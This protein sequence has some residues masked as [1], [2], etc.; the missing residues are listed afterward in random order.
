SK[1]HDEG[2]LAMVLEAAE[3]LIGSIDDDR[4]KT[5]Y[6]L[7]HVTELY[8]LADYNTALRICETLHTQLNSKEH[9]E[10]W[11]QIRSLH[12]K[13]LYAMDDF[14]RADSLFDDFEH[15]Q[16][17]LYAAQYVG[18]GMEISENY[19]LEKFER[20]IK[21]QELLLSNTYYQRYG[22]ITGIVV[23]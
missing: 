1:I 15:A 3:P 21:E 11:R 6:Q 4:L 13:I 14:R 9:Y 12:F 10:E 16:D 18:Q 22:L 5:S 8:F 20:Q 19:K 17:S 23:L 2:R 7:L